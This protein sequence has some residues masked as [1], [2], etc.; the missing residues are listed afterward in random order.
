MPR[1]SDAAGRPSTRKQRHS[2]PTPTVRERPHLAPLAW[3]NSTPTLSSLALLAADLG[4]LA[5]SV[6]VVILLRRL[7]GYP[8]VPGVAGLVAGGSAWLCL[9][10]YA[11][12]YPGQG[13]ALPEE[14]RRATLT[15]LLAAFA[16]A[17]SLFALKSTD[18]SRFLALGMW[19]ALLPI[20]WMIRG[21]AKSALLRARMY[22]R[23]VI[24]L[25]AGDIGKLVVDEL[26][27]HRGVGLVPVGMFDDDAAKIGTLV[28]GVPVLG[29][30]RDAEQYGFP[31]VVRDAI[32]ATPSLGGNE[33][34][35]LARRF[36]ARYPSLRIIPDLFGLGNLW[37]DVTS[38]GTCLTL[39]LRHERFE[40]S[41]LR[42]KRAFD[43]V[44]GIP[45][46]ALAAPVIAVLVILLKL[47]N[48]GPAFYSQVREGLDGRLIR[49]WK[50]RTMVADAET[51]LQTYLGENGEARAEW[52]Q[53]MKL[54]DDPRVIPW[55]GRF[56]RRSSL[57]ELPQLWNVLRGELSLVGPRP[58]P[59]Y[60][61][62]RFSPE[63]VIL[64]RQVPPGVT[65]YWQVTARSNSDLQVQ[66]AADSFYVHN[67][68]PWLDLWI[69]VRTVRVVLSGS[70][71]Y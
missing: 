9:R 13:L 65:G 68:S 10:W 4:A 53:R 29:S 60:H 39:Q 14:F 35:R 27:N 71:A 3:R 59:H 23:P 8:D 58:F 19:G 24:I 43:L 31:Y 50:I 55:I 66:E 46:F 2:A 67:W 54:R 25:G 63:F 42:M 1:L 56:M 61:V 48:R 37:V 33:L 38:V 16:H 15:T 51:R 49:I 6:L 28:H 32:I 64:R 44:L 57:D 70:G 12:L 47:L 69:L 62:E 26:V 11:E 5:I 17:A 40:A 45:L 22:G 41:A 34:V 21:L 18:A 52:N 30:W 20:S 7:A 36:A